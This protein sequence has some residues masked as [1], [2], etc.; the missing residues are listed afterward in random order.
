MKNKIYLTAIAS[1][2]LLVTP[3]S[4]WAAAPN[5]PKPAIPTSSPADEL[6]QTG[7]QQFRAKQFDLAIVS[8]Q[9]ALK[10][11]QQQKNHKG[12]IK[13]LEILAEASKILGKYEQVIAYSQQVLALAQ[14]LGDRQTEANALGDLGNSYR[15][16]GNYAKALEVQN[17]GLAIREELREELND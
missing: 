15:V 12:T 8:W 17:Q 5:N 4:S 9:Q 7:L 6:V 13:V 10:I 3:F 16:I 11:Y 14:S 1:V 2:I